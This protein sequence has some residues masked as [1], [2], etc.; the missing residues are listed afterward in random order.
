MLN[1]ERP[2]KEPELPGFNSGDDEVHSRDQRLR[3][4]RL[5]LNLIGLVAALMVVTSLWPPRLIRYS[6]RDM[7]LDG[8]P[9]NLTPQQAID[10]MPASSYDITRGH[11]FLSITA[12]SSGA[13][14]S[15]ITFQKRKGQLVL[16]EIAGSRVRFKENTLVE[17][18]DS[19][20]SVLKRFPTAQE[21]T[22]SQGSRSLVFRQDDSWLEFLVDQSDLGVTLI[23][24]Q[25]E[26]K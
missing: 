19:E 3:E 4:L 23:R 9:Y 5:A 10:R 22:D 6:W 7:R 25:R 13:C 16:S 17:L 15:L 11:D 14:P 2:R 21:S 1:L 26:V 24:Y 8:I 18:G 20:S 12:K